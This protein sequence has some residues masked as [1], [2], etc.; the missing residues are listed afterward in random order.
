MLIKFKH[1]VIENFLSFG[2]AE[3]D[4]NDRGYATVNGVN[5]CI[6]DN[7]QSNGAGKSSLWEALAYSICGET[8]RGI[9]SNLINIHTTGGMK[10][11]ITFDIDNIP[12]K[13]IRSKDH[14][15]LG[16]TIKFYVNGEDKSGKGVRDTE[17]II[18]EYLPDLTNELIGNV[19][20]LGQGM[21]QKFTNNT[22]SGRKEVL[23]KLSKSD[24]MIED[25]K[26]RLTNRKV[27]LNKELKDID[28]SLT[29]SQSK[30]DIYNKQLPQFEKQLQELTPPN[31]EELNNINTKI[32]QL[33]TNIEELTPQLQ[34]F[35]DQLEELN[36]QNLGVTNKQALEVSQIKQEYQD[37]IN[38]LQEQKYALNAE[39]NSLNSEIKKLKDITDICPT[40]GQKLPN[41]HK[42]DTT[43]K[44]NKLQELNNQLQEINNN[45]KSIE[46]ERDTKTKSIEEEYKQTR[47]DITNKIN[48]KKIDISNTT[49]QIDS[50]N[51][52]IKHQSIALVALQSSLNNY[53]QRKNE[54]ISNIEATK[55]NIGQLNSKIM[56]DTMSKKDIEDRLDA[57][58]KMTTLATRDFR[59]FLLTNAIGYINKR[60][61]IY[62]QD[63]FGTDKIK[64]SL[65]GNNLNVSYDEKLYENLSGGEQKRVDLISQLSI[66]DMLVQFSN[67]SSNILVLDEI[68]ENLDVKSSD[69]VVNTINK[70]L[71]DIESI[72][73]VTHRSNLSL[74]TDATITV[75]KDE[76][77]VS[78]L[79]DAI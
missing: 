36:Q 29:A 70:R 69:A 59:G 22:P 31:I 25:I 53:E 47:L 66:R 27:I 51:S 13:I 56:Y 8:I 58:N 24:F 48:T 19:I 60:A 5:N 6:V 33:N 45:I 9:K 63:I 32:N 10:I 49:K 72:F 46:F 65:D 7:A 11:E 43:D 75:I 15:E 73:I 74:P 4:L 39:I 1:L 41:V 12:Y 20:I 61:K 18:S 55:Q 40:C 17:K 21:P 54:L 26:N 2:Y 28:L 57:I 52:E 42:V 37:R 16:T 50:Y 35:K 67:F 14:K 68:F 78:R 71:T 23:E 76:N 34:L 64:F 77:G 79:E 62:S 44:E 38:K 30:L 3:L